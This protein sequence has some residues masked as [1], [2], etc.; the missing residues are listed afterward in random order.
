MSVAA[1]TMPEL[2]VRYDKPGPRYTSYPTAVEFHDGVTDSVILWNTE[3][4]GYL[5][6]FAA[7][8]VAKG[9]LKAGDKTLKAGTLGEFQI[10]GDSIF[11]GKPFTFNKDNIDKFDF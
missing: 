3:D 6:I 8:A 1:P 9:N 7:D 11:L 2:L 4:L 5:A 10:E